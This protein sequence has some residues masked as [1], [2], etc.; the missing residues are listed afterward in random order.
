MKQNKLYIVVGIIAVL[1]VAIGAVLLSGRITNRAGRAAVAFEEERNRSSS[2]QEYTSPDENGIAKKVQS[3]EVATPEIMMLQFQ[4]QYR[5]PLDSRPLT[6]TMTDLTEPFKIQPA[7]HP[8]YAHN[9]PGEDEKP[10]LYYS[11]SGP[12]HVVTANSPAVAFLEVFD[13]DGN[14]VKPRVISADVYSDFTFGRKLA[15]QATSEAASDG[16]TKITWTPRAGERLHWGEIELR[17]LFDT[18]NVKNNLVVADFSSTPTAPALFTG[19]YY[20]RLE[21]GSLIIDASIDV[22]KAGKYVFDANIFDQSGEPYGRVHLVTYLE[23]GQ[24]KLP[25]QFFGIIFHDR[26]FNQGKLVLKNLR[27]RR[28]NL[29]FDP[30]KLDGMLARGEV[31]PTN[32]EPLDE[33]IPLPSPDYVTGRA[34]DV[35][36]FSQKEYEGLDKAERLKQVQQYARDWEKQ[37]GQS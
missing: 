29:P 17:V 8:I 3:A 23:R 36:E 14:V 15:G 24:Q 30:R 18:P 35:D 19:D 7:R 4:M 33:W 5:Y 32:T 1:V 31:I 28:M 26:E 2:N 27:G 12:S 16:K 34:Y 25:L 6:R 22:K 13:L 11:W 37:N 10:L 21:N 9:P 20:D